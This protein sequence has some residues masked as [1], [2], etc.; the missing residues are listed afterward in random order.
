MKQ[1]KELCRL[2]LVH[3][4]TRRAIAR[5]CC[6]S[7]S[8]AQGYIQRLD[9]LGLDWS[10]LEAM[11]QEELEGLLRGRRP[12]EKAAAK[13][14]PDLQYIARE[15]KK[16]GVTL[17]L[18][19]EEYRESHPDGY[20]RTQF[21][22]L[23]RDWMKDTWPTMRLQHKAGDKMFVDFSGV[24]ASYRDPATGQVIEAELYV[25][26][27]GAS[28]YTFACAVASQKVPDFIGAT[29]KALE[30]F[31]GAPNCVVID[32]L[33]SGVTHACYWDPEINQAFAEMA[34][35]YGVVVLPTRVSKPK[36]KAKVESGVLNAQRRILAALRNREFFNLQELN[37]AISQ[38]V[39]KLNARP[40][41]VTGRSR[42]E[43]FEELEKAQLKAL[44][45]VRFSISQWKKAKVHIDYHVDVEKTYYSVPYGLIG[46]I[47]E[48]QYDQRTVQIY[49]NGKRVAAHPRTVRPGQY[50]TDSAHMPHEHRYYLEWTPERIQK[51]GATIGPHTRD[52]IEKI[53]QSKAH[54]E[55][56]FRGCLGIIRLASPYTPQRVEQACYRALQLG[57][58]SFRSVKSMLEK[59]LD[60]IVPF[61]LPQR[62]ETIDHE[63]L[64]GESYYDADN[65]R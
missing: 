38:E 52:L 60:K 22:G 27:L 3:K 55:H 10:R 34:R 14:E 16:P 37:A 63:N 54:P 26:V 62:S 49:C 58:Y 33:K 64:R 15:M 42:R 6:M 46:K 53:M 57:A 1:I 39:T 5:A 43:L 47:V 61:D 18:L 23:C 35:H 41:Q 25:A 51:W 19:W 24:K 29:I 8:T 13:P 59:G 2:H 20:G 11:G 56:A 36:D 30:F 9:S 28:S 12:K 40:M 32:N 50:V 65:T 31:G 17:Q 4:L 21:Y 7:A 44:P 48:I 45:P